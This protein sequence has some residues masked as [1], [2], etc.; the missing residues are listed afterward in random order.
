MHR[1]RN[2]LHSVL[3]GATTKLA[4]LNPFHGDKE[5]VES[6]AIALKR[7]ARH[8]TDIGSVFGKTIDLRERLVGDLLPLRE[9]LPWNSPGCLDILG[10]SMA[11]VRELQLAN[12]DLQ[13]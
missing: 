1:I 3:C 11:Q 10:N 5:L 8:G 12:E 13:R 7:C 4:I 9:L 2:Q 6:V